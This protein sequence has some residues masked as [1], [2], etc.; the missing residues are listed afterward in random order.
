MTGNRSE[1]SAEACELVR[2]CA[3][4]LLEDAPALQALYDDAVAAAPEEH[5][6][7]AL[8]RA[9]RR[10]S[11]ANI[12]HWLH[13]LVLDPTAPVAPNT[14]F[15][16]V[17]PAVDVY[18]RGL[19]AE[20]VEAYRAAQHLLAKLWTRI[21]FAESD[22]PRLA[23]E[24]VI[25]GTDS[26]DDFVGVT[27]AAFFDRI[28]DHRRT[29]G[30]ADQ[31]SA[32]GTVKL[33]IDGSPIT[34]DRAQV[35]LQY[36]FA[37][38]HCAAVVWADGP[39]TALEHHVDATF[40]ALRVDQF[41]VV[42]AASDALWLWWSDARR[43]PPETVG[44]A[45]AGA[46]HVNVAVGAVGS[47]RNGFRR[48]HLQARDVETLVMSARRPAQVVTYEQVEPVIIATRE[49]EEAARFVQ[50][51]LGRLLDEP[52]D[53]R[54]TLRTYTRLQSNA[55]ETAR[56]VHAHRNTVINKIDRARAALPSTTLEHPLSLELAL[57]VAHW[58][59]SLTSPATEPGRP[60]T[61]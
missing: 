25:C 39:A 45:L 43:V 34:D 20:S 8:A 17:A 30:P 54:D 50:R 19:E 10:T 32:F 56:A 11:Q 3:Q 4:K 29:L 33:I 42:P 37:D 24:A 2:R 61:R 46:S 41:L 14:S 21:V 40:H 58:L 12:E 26:L 44:A 53:I 16:V 36:R 1:L 27:L 18:R 9:V 52:A 55:T 49:P 51:V 35:R 48:T 22:S 38:H 57:E 5:R 7:P 23:Q 13:H 28:D 60:S 47:G 31:P 15:D 6:E 59:P